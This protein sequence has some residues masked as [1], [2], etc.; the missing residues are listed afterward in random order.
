M[1]P[2]FVLL[3][4]TAFAFATSA[5]AQQAQVTGTV[6]DAYTNARLGHVTVADSAGGTTTHTDGS[7]R[8]SLPC[9]GPAT[10]VFRKSGYEA[11]ER[12][13]ASCSADVHVGLVPG[14]QSLSAV[15]VMA[16]PE[17]P[18]IEQ[19]QSVSVLSPRDL[20]RSS[21]LFLD[22]ALN[23]VPGV[24]MERRTM[25]GGQRITIRGYASG[26]DAGNFVG[27]GYKA[28][29][30]G[31]PITDAEGQ[32]V[33]DDI[34]FANL[35]RVEVI[36]GPASSIYGAGIGGVVNLYT[37]EPHRLGMHVVQGLTGGSDGLFRSDTR[38]ENV[39]STATTMIGYGHQGYDS[40]R[41]HSGSTKDYGSF[42]G[43]FRPSDRRTISTFVSYAHSRDNRAGELDSAQFAQEL[44][45]GEDRYLDNDAHQDIESFRAGVTHRYRFNDHV[46]N[47]ATAYYSGNVLEDVYAAGLNSK[48]NQNFGARVVFN[49]DFA[50]PTLPLRGTS[51]I[52][53]EK[54]NVFA[55]G[56]G[57]TGGVLGALR[58][59]L[60]THT[61][62]YSIFTQWDASLPAAF[63]LTAGASANFI[64][65][66]ITDRMAS[67]A[68]PA[69]QD[70]SG[71]KV[72]DPVVTPRV[73]LRRMFGQHMSVYASVS[74]GYS[75]PTSGDAVIAYTGE[76]NTG[77][78]PE[79]ATQYE[80][81]GKGS[82]FDNRLS[83]S[84][85]LFDLRVTDKLTSQAVFD[86]DGT[87]L[88][89][90]TVNAGDQNDKGLEL[91]AAYALID[92]PARFVS[93]V[94]P[95]I[96]YTYS[97]F[98]YK[99]FKSDH[100]NDA[101]TVDYTGNDVVGVAPNVISL[102]V[103][104]GLRSGIYANATYYDTD[105]MPISYDN[106]H[107]APGYS[108]L[109]ARIGF[110]HDVGGRFTLDAFVGGDNLT[111]SRYYTM[112]FLNHKFDSPTPPHMY[113]PGPYKATY[114]G[115]LKVSIRP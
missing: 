60:E 71:R 105:D 5:A 52:E 93:L 91:A 17:R 70:A 61:M 65:Y 46:E 69:H 114:Y 9:T 115:G 75:P 88:Y 79:R 99:N 15:N 110:A 74:Q 109:N 54:S 106:A 113:L 59:D 73:A 76:P 11:T 16:A 47:V 57:M 100:N 56:Y 53:F 42:L 29:Y 98:T 45:T 28:Y 35:G 6:F 78:E 80:I 41:I 95:F 68:N 87:V 104:A 89:S 26:N 24:R 23:L 22:Q 63:T 107:H 92:D 48:S 112:V 90:Y 66:A 62:Q 10:L 72:F 50:N 85:A 18:T 13:I 31:I 96:S 49:T 19:P 36:R 86:T 20:Q 25:S 27:L 4:F 43:D 51:G 108:L 84:L 12:A 58:S 37:A 97:D 103:D 34:D 39:S 32:T 55:Q 67:S 14:A 81:G 8:F 33:L 21:G 38:L 102:G 111:G 2:F 1:R 64:E 94:R 44:N 82:L 77:L 83:Y 7:G 101:N 40:Y 3:P 30:N